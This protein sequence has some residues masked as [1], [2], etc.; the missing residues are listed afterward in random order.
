MEQIQKKAMIIQGTKNLYSITKQLQGIEE[1][2][3]SQQNQ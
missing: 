2:K 3:G 1:K